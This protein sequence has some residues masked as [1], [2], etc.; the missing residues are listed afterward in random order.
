MIETSNALRPFVFGLPSRIEAAPHLQSKDSYLAVGENSGNLAFAY[1][2]SSHLGGSVTVKALRERPEVINESGDIG[3]ITAANHLG[4][5]V[6]FSSLVENFSMLNCRLVMI[7]LG[8]QSGVGGKIPKVPEGTVNWVREISRRA[9]DG[10]PNIMVRGP[11]TKDVMTHYGLGEACVSLGCPSLFINQDPELGKRIASNVRPI[12]RIAVAAGHQRWTHMSRIEASLTRIVSVTGGSY[13]GQ[14]AYEMFQLTR[15]EASQMDEADLRACRDYA[16]PEMDLGE[17]IRWSE[18][19]GNL[20]F[21]VPSWMEHYRRFDFVIGA[22]IHGVMLALQ[23][24]IPGVCIVHDSRTLELCQTMMV[25]HVLA[26][27]IPHGVTRDQL[28]EL[29]RFD[30]AAFDANRRSL[31]KRY[32]K[33]LENNKISPVYWLKEIASHT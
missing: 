6:N 31:A 18:R 13:V 1:A 17:F 20:F 32:V 16:C 24:G 15:G 30:A 7:G 2:I 8:A 4:E 22:R 27:D 10:H 28:P 25:P 33:F 19:H 23:A 5:H 3:V 21:D 26:R 9:H 29:F 14:S 11:F 12:R